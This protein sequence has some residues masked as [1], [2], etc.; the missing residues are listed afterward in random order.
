MREMRQLQLHPGVIDYGAA[1]SACRS[2]GEWQKALDMPYD[3]RQRMVEPNVRS[4]NAALSVCEKGN[5]WQEAC[6][7]WDKMRWVECR[8]M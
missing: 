6:S 7:L 2:G 5:C 8:Q 1:I 4:Y 3:M